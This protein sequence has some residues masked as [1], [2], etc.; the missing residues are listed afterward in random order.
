MRVISNR[1]HPLVVQNLFVELETGF[2]YSRE[3][4]NLVFRK[5]MV[6]TTSSS[7]TVVLL[8]AFCDIDESFSDVVLGKPSEE[9]ELR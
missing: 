5:N 7:G 4:V 2:I 1:E 9:S 6:N 3:L 8:P